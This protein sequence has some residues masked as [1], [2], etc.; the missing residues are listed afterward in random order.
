MNDLLQYV[1]DADVQAMLDYLSA[2]GFAHFWRLYDEINGS[3]SDRFVMI[4]ARMVESK[5]PIPAALQ[6]TAPLVEPYTYTKVT[7]D[8]LWGKNSS[9]YD[10]VNG[11][12]VK[13]EYSF[14]WDKDNAGNV[15]LQ[16]WYSV[17]NLQSGTALPNTNLH[18][19]FSGSP[20]EYVHI[21]ING[22]FRF[23]NL[24]GEKV[25]EGQ[26]LVVPAFWAYWLLHR[27]NTVERMTFVRQVLDVFAIV[28][29][30]ATANPTPFLI[31]DA[32]VGGT[33]LVFSIGED[34][35]R[36]SG[37]TA[38]NNALDMWDNAAAVYGATAMGRMVFKK[39]TS[40]V[41]GVRET[42]FNTAQAELFLQD[43]RKIPEQL[44]QFADGIGGIIKTLKDFAALKA[45]FK[46]YTVSVLLNLQIRASILADS[47]IL[48]EYA[49]TVKN[50]YFVV[51][52][53][54]RANSETGLM[55]TMLQAD[56]TVVFTELRLY[57][58]NYGAIQRVVAG[59]KGSYKIGDAVYE[60]NI[61]IVET[62]NNQWYVVTQENYAKS[63]NLH[64]VANLP[65]SGSFV[66][67]SGVELRKYLERITEIPNSVSHTKSLYRNIRSDFSDPKFI[68]RTQ[69]SDFENR[70]FTGLYLSET[71]AG[72]L[73][74]A[75]HYNGS[76]T[77]R[78]LYEF[79]QVN[80]SNLLDLTDSKIVN[81][82]G[83]TFNQLKLQNVDNSIQY[84][85]THQIAKWAKE[86]GFSGIKFFGARGGTESYI[87]FV[88]FDE[89]TV[90]TSLNIFKKISW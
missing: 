59:T 81:K 55:K 58:D 66:A 15:V 35:I 60:G 64:F 2:N 10:M 1:N 72:N 5:T 57:D 30:V 4:V 80:I 14:A 40:I 54:S 83:V 25:Q 78:D 41:N 38:L 37:N 6:Y 44:K 84:E 82:L 26:V 56:G 18:R 68:Y 49:F 20:F 73:F 76:T 67:K 9:S 36:S 63:I 50:N 45:E 87:N 70:Y 85:F 22:D 13:K 19:K 33:D 7:N 62:S 53:L 12:S 46:N 65:F 89:N 52:A 69:T 27:Q 24:E 16:Y 88:I 21:R 17:T 43:I 71:K 28:S 79:T 90:N 8:L 77:N 23:Q 31:V 3:Q 86:K 39:A 34:M 75:V 61:V 11:N 29:S 51:Q 42:R 74:E 48:P 47:W 32:A